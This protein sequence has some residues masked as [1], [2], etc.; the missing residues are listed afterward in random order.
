LKGDPNRLLRALH[1]APGVPRPEREVAVF[2]LLHPRE[3]DQVLLES[4]THAAVGLDRTSNEFQTIRI[5][6]R[7]MLP[8]LLLVEVFSGVTRVAVF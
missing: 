4:A 1:E 7:P 5:A 3:L 8:V 6:P 2:R